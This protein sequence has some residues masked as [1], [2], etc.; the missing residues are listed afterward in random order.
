MGIWDSE[1]LDET[2]DGL[3]TGLTGPITDQDSVLTAFG[4]LQNQITAIAGISFKRDQFTGVFGT[5]TYTLSFSPLLDSENV[6]YNGVPEIRDPVEGYS[7]SG[8]QITFNFTVRNN[9]KIIVLYAYT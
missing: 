8:N 5:Q 7:I 6:I 3:D 2:L 1:I 9:R 4:R